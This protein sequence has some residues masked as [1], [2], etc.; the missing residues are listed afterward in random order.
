MNSVSTAVKLGAENATTNM[1]ITN[2]SMQPMRVTGINET[3]NGSNENV[4]V[5]F[6]RTLTSDLQKQIINGEQDVV[7]PK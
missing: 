7:L 5:R 3:A 4:T 2:S 6:S 1:V